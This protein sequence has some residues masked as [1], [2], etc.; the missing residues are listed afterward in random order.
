[1]PHRWW[2]AVPVPLYQDAVAEE[3]VFTLNNCSARFVVAGDQEQVDKIVDARDEL[4]NIAHIV[5][6]DGRGLRKYDHS[7]LTSYKNLQENGLQS[8]VR[9]AACTTDRRFK[10]R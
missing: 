2:G 10:A 8:G 6:L 1:M 7:F 5:Y 3:I 9:R 4:K